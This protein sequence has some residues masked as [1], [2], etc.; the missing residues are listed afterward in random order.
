MGGPGGKTFVGIQFHTFQ[1]GV[2]GGMLSP[3]PIKKPAALD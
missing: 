1:G 2:S 3:L